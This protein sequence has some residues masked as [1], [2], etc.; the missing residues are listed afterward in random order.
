MKYNAYDKNLY[1]KTE[2][3]PLMMEIQQK[4][5]ENKIPFFAAFGTKMTPKGVFPKGDGIVSMSIIP[6]AI[7]METNDHFFSDFVNVLNGAYT[8]YVKPKT[9]I[10]V[11]SL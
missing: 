9:D 2:I 10:D 4:C 5:N 6:E 8:V 3:F 11:D 7:P 1:W